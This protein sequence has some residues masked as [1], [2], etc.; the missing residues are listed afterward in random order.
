MSCTI[1]LGFPSAPAEPA[2]VVKKNVPIQ[3]YGQ[4][5]WG[6]GQSKAVALPAP[7]SLPVRFPGRH[8]S[9]LGEGTGNRK[10]RR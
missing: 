2:G 1:A 6:E 3:C 7:G 4:E 8:F 9:C 5:M 10:G